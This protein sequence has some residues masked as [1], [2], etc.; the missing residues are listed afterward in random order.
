M[1]G[2]VALQPARRGIRVALFDQS[3]EPFCGAS[4]WNE[5]KIHFGY[6][7]GADPTLQT[8]KK[9]IPGGLSFRPLVQDLLGC[10]IPASSVTAHDDTYLVH[11]DSVA[12]FDQVFALAQCV[13][14]LAEQHPDAGDHFVGLAQHRPRRLSTETLAR[15]SGSP[16]VVGG[17]SAPERSVSTQDI[18]DLYVQAL[19]ANALIEPHMRHRVLAVRPANRTQ[20][21]WRIRTRCGDQTQELGPFDAV[22]NALWEGRGAIDAALGLS[23]AETWTNR[24]RLSLF[25]TAEAPVA[26]DSAVLCV[27]PFGDVKNYDSRRFYLSWYDAGLQLS[28]A[29]LQPPPPPALDPATREAVAQRTLTELGRLIPGVQ[30]LAGRLASV[31]VQGGWVH[32]AGSGS[33]RDARSGLHRRD[34]IGLVQIGR[35]FSIDT[36]KYSIA[37]WLALQLSDALCEALGR[38]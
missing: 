1:G 22:V 5:G 38:G 7:Y 28:S 3:P 9:L 27:G 30:A 14:E 6:L 25:A 13:A 2:S 12:G 18:A 17:F 31:D 23:R 11:R 4:R 33:L 37:P 35:Y 26:L 20:T 36:G 32:S 8:A 34:N 21:A 15:I 10:P 19:A 16:E 29:A 24:Y